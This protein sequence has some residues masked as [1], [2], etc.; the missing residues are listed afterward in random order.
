[1]CDHRDL[2]EKNYDPV[3]KP[4]DHK[5]LKDEDGNSNEHLRDF[6]VEAGYIEY[7]KQCADDPPFEEEKEKKKQ[8][9]RDYD[10]EEEEKKARERI[11]KEEKGKERFESMLIKFIRDEVLDASDRDM[12][13]NKG[14]SEAALTVLESLHS[15]NSEISELI[16]IFRNR[17]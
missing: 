15:Y 11:R 13:V 4:C 1:M 16:R 10:Y 17:T 3:P 8:T 6:F 14:F 9:W 2:Y 5:E 7:C 12:D